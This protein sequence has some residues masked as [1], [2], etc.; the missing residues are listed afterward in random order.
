M[1][2][3]ELCLIVKDSGE[4]IVKALESWKKHID[5]WTILDTGSTDGTPKRIR[6]VLKDIPG[7]LY[8]EPQENFYFDCFGNKEVQQRLISKLGRLPFDFAKARNR[9]LE[10]CSKKC[11][12]IITIDD[13]YVIVN[14]DLLRK[15]LENVKDRPHHAFLIYIHNQELGKPETFNSVQSVR[16]IRSNKGYKWVNPIHEVL[17]VGMEPVP[18]I[19]LDNDTYI[20]DE[21]AEYYTKRS[22]DRHKRDI[23]VLNVCYENSTE[24][25]V[26]SRYAYYAAQTA[27]ILRDNEASGLWLKRRIDTD[28]ENSTELY[29]ALTQYARYTKDRTY[30]DRAIEMIPQRLEA[31][32]ESALI[33]YSNKC[34]NVAYAYLKHGLFFHEST[35]DK[36]IM[37][38]TFKLDIFNMLVKLALRFGHHGDAVV[39]IKKGLE[40][41]GQNE[42]LLKYMDTCKKLG[43]WEVYKDVNELVGGNQDLATNAITKALTNQNEDINGYQEVIFSDKP[44]KRVVFATDATST[45]PWDGNS[46]NVRGSETSIIKTA[47]LLATLTTI[48]ETGKTIPKYEVVVFCDTPYQCSKVINNVTWQN[49]NTFEKYLEK[50]HVD[51]VI[52]VR[53][54]KIINMLNKYVKTVRNHYFWIH[55]I[56]IGG[57]SLCLSKIAFRKLIYVSQYQQKAIMDHF[58]FPESLCTV[59]PNGLDIKYIE[60]LE[61]KTMGWPTQKVKNRFIYSSDANRGL[62]DLLNM[63]PIIRRLL[64]GATLH[65]YCDLQ[66]TDADVFEKGEFRNICL[67]NLQKIRDTIKKSAKDYVVVHG[68]VGKDKLYRGFAEAEYWF[69]PCIF[70]ETFCITALEAQYFKCKVICNNLGALGDVVKSGI[71]YDI[72]TNPVEVIPKLA[73]HSDWKLETGH[74]WAIEHSYD[75]I[76]EK[77]VRLFNG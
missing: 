59:I 70:T 40:C 39:Y 21:V 7:K 69:Y 12:Y 66:K 65:I 1:A 48:D 57:E 56:S 42:E 20:Y 27:I 8:E 49:I 11:E 74:R 15:K 44:Y 3:I 16:I 36:E 2:L 28:P 22:F 31:Y 47:N 76:V 58:S 75:N 50:T 10:L 17:D 68:R 32:L 29:H 18:N 61:H 35:R 62:F 63:F 24:P 64:P 9:S 72:K 38:I 33:S 34:Y 55:D 60:E 25:K 13:T 4:K 51:H 23:E 52:S 30:S 19:T 43:I 67:A 71:V 53:S 41:N 6:E 37:F 77:W 5:Y 26:K 45:G 73:V 14:P 54:I 46:L